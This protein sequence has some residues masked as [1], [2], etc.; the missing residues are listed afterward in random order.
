MIYGNWLRW[1]GA[2]SL[3]H[4][5]SELVIGTSQ[6]KYVEPVSADTAISGEGILDLEPHSGNMTFGRFVDAGKIHLEAITVQLGK[7]N[8]IWEA[9]TLGEDVEANPA[10]AAF[11]LEALQFVG[12]S[13]FKLTDTGSVDDDFVYIGELL[14]MGSTRRIDLNDVALLTDMSQSA[15]LNLLPYVTNTGTLGAPAVKS[16]QLGW[17]SWYWYL[18]PEGLVIPEIIPEPASLAVMLLGALALRR[19]RA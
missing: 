16:V 4:A 17:E 11:K 19:R 13:T 12:N 3:P 6:W 1:R 10:A 5:D 14:G 15:L 18:A 8:F 2:I 7:N 9:Q